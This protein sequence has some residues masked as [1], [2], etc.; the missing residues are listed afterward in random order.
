MKIYPLL[1]PR[2]FMLNVSGISIVTTFVSVYLKLTHIDLD[3]FLLDLFLFLS[4]LGAAI[5][6]FVVL[7][8]IIRNPYKNKWLWIIPLLF[9]GNIV[10]F[11]FLLNRNGHINKILK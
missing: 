2:T 8:D 4:V 9:V 1:L 5:S 11:V 6:V 3:L 10:A 7:V